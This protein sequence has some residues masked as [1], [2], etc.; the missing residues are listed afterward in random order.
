MCVAATADLDD[1]D[2]GRLV[3]MGI[4]SDY[5]VVLKETSFGFAVVDACLPTAGVPSSRLRYV[6]WVS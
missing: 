4:Y 2:D 3:K 6:M 5:V 1:N